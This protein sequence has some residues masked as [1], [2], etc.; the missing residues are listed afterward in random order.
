LNYPFFW[1]IH[2]T[3]IIQ[4]T[5]LNLWSIEILIS[6]LG[7]TRALRPLFRN[8]LAC[9]EKTLGLQPI[10]LPKFKQGLKCSPSECS[11]KALLGSMVTHLKASVKDCKKEVWVAG[12]QTWWHGPVYNAIVV[13]LWTCVLS[14]SG[15]NSFMFLPFASDFPFL[16]HS[17]FLPIFLSKVDLI[18]S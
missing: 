14:K 3:Y 5:K 10:L 12:K 16:I 18:P 6:I 2:I 11:E 17:S 9:W 8:W 4:I 13:G 15:V 7:N 1:I